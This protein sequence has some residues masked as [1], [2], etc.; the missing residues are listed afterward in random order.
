MTAPGQVPHTHIDIDASE[1]FFRLTTESIRQFSNEHQLYASISDVIAAR[2]ALALEHSRY[3]DARM[4]SAHLAAV[5]SHG[6]VTIQLTFEEASVEMID[7]MREELSQIISRAL[8]NV[9]AISI[10]LFD[11]IAEQE[12]ARLATRLGFY[13]DD[14]KN[15][16]D[17]LQSH[18]EN[19]T[20]MRTH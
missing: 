12:S 8:S 9:D 13:G 20:K 11:Y 2:T 16:R 3:L 1:A 7:A 14:A 17:I 15:Y 4:I 10:L 19:V 5:E 6:P 18:R